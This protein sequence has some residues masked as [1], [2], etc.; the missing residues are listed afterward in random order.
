MAE[1]P[2][3]DEEWLEYYA[4]I[5]TFVFERWKAIAA[6]SPDDGIDEDA[7]ENRWNDC[8]TEGL[9][10]I[11]AS[12]HS[13]VQREVSR[14]RVRALWAQWRAKH[15]LTRDAVRGVTWVLWRAWEHFWGAIGLVAFGLLLLWAFPHFVREMRS[16]AD[17]LLPAKSSPYQDAGSADTNQSRGQSATAEK[18]PEN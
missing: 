11:R 18:R 5:G 3:T 6:D 12:S 10:R 17:V 13:L 2:Q 16:R 1:I 15:K 4:R 8:T 7:H 9:E 14:Q